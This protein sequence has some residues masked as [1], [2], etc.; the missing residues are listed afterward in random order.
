MKTELIVASKKLFEAFINQNLY[1]R[2]AYIKFIEEKLHILSFQSKNEPV[3]YRDESFLNTLLRNRIKNIK[4]MNL[5]T[6]ERFKKRDGSFYPF[7]AREFFTISLFRD[8]ENDFINLELSDFPEDYYS[9][10]NQSLRSLVMISLSIK[11]WFTKKDSYYFRLNGIDKEEIDINFI[12][13][14]LENNEEMVKILEKD[15]LKN[16]QEMKE[17]FVKNP[18]FASLYS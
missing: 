14:I 15:S 8:E 2:I 5:R 7:E 4:S 6:L 9:D 3:P 16:A 12:E 13:S 18:D 10:E 17:F 11:E 1:V